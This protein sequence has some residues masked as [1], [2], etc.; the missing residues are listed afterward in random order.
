MLKKTISSSNFGVE[1][2]FLFV[3]VFFQGCLSAM[4]AMQLHFHTQTVHTY[5][6]TAKTEPNRNLMNGSIR[7]LESFSSFF[8][9]S[10]PWMH[11]MDRRPS[12]S[13]L[14]G[15]GSGS[16]NGSGNGIDGR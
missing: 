6:Q 11:F 8:F 13:F 12:V 14:P 10:N 15:S 4:P 16:G 5:T 2:C 9:I 3:S 7:A 1:V